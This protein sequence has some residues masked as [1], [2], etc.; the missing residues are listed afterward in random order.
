MSLK[1]FFPKKVYHCSCVNSV[2]TSCLLDGIY[3]LEDICKEINRVK[4]VN[5]KIYCSKCGDNMQDAIFTCTEHMAIV[6]VSVKMYDPEKLPDKAT[7]DC[8]IELT[9]ITK[10]Y[11]SKCVKKYLRKMYYY[12]HCTN[13]DLPMAAK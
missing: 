7:D 5:K 6:I 8:N 12:Y 4:I 3:F 9:D 13:F 1:Y 2:V 11:C 10:T